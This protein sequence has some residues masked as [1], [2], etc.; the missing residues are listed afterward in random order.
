MIQSVDELL[1]QLR[2]VTGPLSAP[3]AEPMNWAPFAMGITIAMVVA[4]A[5]VWWRRPRRPA[6]PD[7]EALQALKG[8]PSEPTEVTLASCEAIVRRYLGRRYHRPADV[9][10]PTEFDGEIKCEW[11][12]VLQALQVR[13]FAP[14]QSAPEEWPRLIRQLES[15]IQGDCEGVAGQ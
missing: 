3:P 4:G 14:V 6:P 10:T 2:P 5:W 7:V 12:E 11:R 8:L 13:R 15:L 9:L 1:G